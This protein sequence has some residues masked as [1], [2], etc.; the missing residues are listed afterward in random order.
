[1]AGALSYDDYLAKLGKAGFENAAI[2]VT[3]VYAVEDAREFLTGQA[4]DI[5]SIAREVDGKFVSGFVRATKPA[6]AAS[7][8]AKP[9][10]ESAEACCASSCCGRS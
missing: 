6:R 2:E 9:A 3:R 8:N 5:D 7:T 10:G 4:I 1:V